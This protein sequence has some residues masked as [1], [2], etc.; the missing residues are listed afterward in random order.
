ML[1]RY[2]PVLALA[3][4]L[5][6]LA[7]GPAP[8]AS[9]QSG[10]TYLFTDLGSLGGNNAISNAYDVNATGQVVGGANLSGKNPPEHA[11]YWDAQTGR[12]DLGHLGGNFSRAWSLNNGG[13]V[14][15][16]STTAAGQ[17]RAFLWD[18]ATGILSDLNDR[19][20]NGLLDH[21]D[22]ILSEA[23]EI[24]DRRQVIGNGYHTVGGTTT[25]QVFRMDLATGAVMDLGLLPGS[26]LQ[27]P[28]S[29][30][31]RT[32][33]GLPAPQ[34]GV[35]ERLSTGATEYFL[36][37]D[38]LRS[39]LGRLMPNGLNDRGEVAGNNTALGNRAHYWDG[40]AALPGQDLGTLGG[41]SSTAR[42]INN[43]SPAVLVG[44]AATASDGDHAFR[45]VVGSP[46]IQDLNP[47]ASGRGQWVLRLGASISDGGHIVGTARKG[48]VQHAFLL[49]PSS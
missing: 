49:T 7:V 35:S 43:W 28:F 4:G 22:W 48:N 37:T 27:W 30:N 34:I 11:F 45:W 44:Q 13:E 42:E 19:D 46:A 20:G 31:N 12:R 32:V 10:G 5:L 39:P 9:S 47:L 3:A 33:D 18:R 8:P 41:S 17:F 6:A 21:P 24:N 14:V 25:R 15:G 2:R 40:V 29:L 38:G 16:L 36:F 26:T 23:T 1:P